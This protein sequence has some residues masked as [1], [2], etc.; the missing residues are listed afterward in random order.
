MPILGKMLWQWMEE[1]GAGVVWE[2]GE[3]W[4]T[5]TLEAGGRPGGRCGAPVG[6]V[7]TSS[8]HWGSEMERMHA[9]RRAAEGWWFGSKSF[10][11]K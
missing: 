8:S 9:R 2:G 11:S 5:F 7:D 3:D 10:L 1:A 6:P 4:V